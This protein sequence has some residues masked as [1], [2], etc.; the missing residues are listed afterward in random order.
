MKKYIIYFIIFLLLAIGLMVILNRVSNENLDH[1]VI[2]E[3]SSTKDKEIVVNNISPQIVAQDLEIPWD[4]AFLP[5][6]RLLV[7]ERIG[8]LSIITLV[9]TK[10]I[11]HEQTVRETG[12]GGL[13]GI[14]LHPDFLINNYIYL[15][16]T[17]P[18]DSGETKNR[19]ER[20][21][22]VNDQLTDRL[23]LLDDIPGA[24][25]HDGGR[26]EFGPDGFLYVT[27]GDA[28]RPQIAQDKNSLGGKILRLNDD[29]SIP[30][31]NPFTNAI[32]SFGHRNPQGLAWDTAG[33]LWSTEHGRSGLTS[34]L[35]EINLIKLG[36]NYGWPDSEGD[37]VKAGTEAPIL[38]SGSDVTWAPASAAFLENRL[39]VGALAGEAL[40]EARLSN[41]EI[42]ELKRHFYQQYGRIRTVK[43]GPDGWLYLLTSN[44]DGRGR[45]QVGDDIIIRLDPASLK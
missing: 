1:P 38:H 2:T 32:Y 13:L 19:I 8:R 37:K 23:V 3:V 40:Y 45:I 17:S 25:Y 34:G 33:R 30:L 16:F 24:I 21:Q 6:G 42:V 12:E 22:L 9:G 14:V 44:R 18:P 7:S 11:I 29:G 43:V 15:Y 28:T 39:F 4:I 36:G 26:M 27:T 31:N 10:K 41:G 5:D 35:D 20:Y